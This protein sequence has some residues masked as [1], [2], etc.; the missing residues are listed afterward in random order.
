MTSDRSAMEAALKEVCVPVLRSLG[1]RGSFPHFYREE[2]D[3]VSLL[4]FQYFLSGGSFC[5]NLGYADPQRENVYFRK[6][7][8]A[9]ALHVSQTRDHARLGAP[10]GHGDRW[11]SFGKTTYGE[12]RGAPQPPRILAAEVAKL[13]EADA[14]SWWSTKRE[15]AS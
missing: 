7:T 6:E 12:F 15:I 8:K 13:I 2:G 14:V 10:A 11:F 3:F 4:N 9:S 1:F 5:V